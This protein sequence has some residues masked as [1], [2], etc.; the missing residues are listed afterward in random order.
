[1]GHIWL[2]CSHSFLGINSTAGLRNWIGRPLVHTGKDILML[3]GVTE[4]MNAALSS[5]A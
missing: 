3:S 5:V 1:M 4:A 2:S